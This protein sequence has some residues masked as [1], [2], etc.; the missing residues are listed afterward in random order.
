MVEVP[1]WEEPVRG[2]FGDPS[3]LR[4][5]G[6][7]RM[8]LTVRREGSPPPIHHLT[9]LTP[10]EAGTSTFSMRVTPWLLSTVPGLMTRGVLAFLA[11]GPLGTA[12]MTVLPPLGYM[13]SSDLSLSFLQP[14]T[15]DSGTLIGRARLIHG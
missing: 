12:I 4:L 8:R 11:D 9:G 13:T 6:I 5:S 2:T 7:E 15:L 3:S 10:V 14:G 1:I